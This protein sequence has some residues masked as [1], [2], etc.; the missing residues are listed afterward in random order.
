M[1]S[2]WRNVISR[3]RLPVKSPY[4]AMLIILTFFLSCGGGAVAGMTN[5]KNEIAAGPNRPL[6]QVAG[7]GDY[8]VLQKGTENLVDD[9]FV[10][11][12]LAYK[13]SQKGAKAFSFTRSYRA[14]ELPNGENRA[15]IV[16]DTPTKLKM[17]SYGVVVDESLGL[18][19]DDHIIIAGEKF[20][21]SGITAGTS[22]LGKEGVFLSPTEFLRLGNDTGTFTGILVKGAKPSAEL[23]SRYA[24][25]PAAEFE[26]ANLQ[27]WLTNGGSLPLL[28]AGLMTVGSLIIVLAVLFLG[29]SQTRKSLV[30]LRMAGATVDQV[31]AIEVLYLAVLWAVSLAFQFMVYWLLVMIFRLTTFGYLGSLSSGEFLGGAAAMA[32]VVVVY[33]VILSVYVRLK[34]K[35]SQLTEA[36]IG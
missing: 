21:I 17:G 32:T 9:S 28:I 7:P 33:A 11:R 3:F 14:V 18:Q 20:I 10:P 12:D 27:Y 29:L 30:M 36:F 16:F 35:T 4:K 13:L 25:F 22:S 6:Q 24:V 31:V 2:V 5:M 8:W 1:N 23:T 26:D 19:I 34:F 15:A